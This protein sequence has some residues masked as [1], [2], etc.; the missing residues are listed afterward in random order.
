MLSEEVPVETVAPAA[1]QVTQDTAIPAVAE[2]EILEEVPLFNGGVIKKIIRQGT[3][4]CPV[5]GSLVTCH[6]VGRLKSNGTQFDSSRDRDEP[7]K[8]RTI[9]SSRLFFVPHLSTF[10]FLTHT[11]SPPLDVLPSL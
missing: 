5:P 9:S 8:V 7:F 11:M 6:Y 10:P 2:P 3:G 4:T 1:A